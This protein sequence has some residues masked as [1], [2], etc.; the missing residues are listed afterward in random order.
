M[1]VG[2]PSAQ[3]GNVGGVPYELIGILASVPPHLQALYSRSADEEVP[4]YD[5]PRA[6]KYGPSVDKRDTSRA[7][8]SRTIG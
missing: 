4:R 8:R 1:I 6:S 5:S 7:I 3:N 2:S